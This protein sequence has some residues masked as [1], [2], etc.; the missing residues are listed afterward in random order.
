MIGGDQAGVD[1]LDP[2]F[3][4]LAPGRGD[5]RAHRRPRR[6]GDARAE[7]GY[8]HAGPNG[9]GHFVK[10][11]HNGIEYGM[12]QAIAEGFDILRN[13][14]RRGCPRACARPRPRRHRRGLAAR[15]RRHVVAARS[16]GGGAGRGSRARRV[17]GPRGGLRR[18]PLDGAGR[19]RGGGAGRRADRLALHALPLAPGPHLRREGAVG[20]AQGFGGH[21]EPKKSG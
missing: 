1:R 20:D 12:M 11:I 16:D 21:V 17:L 6:A 2:I 7:Q 4:A 15:Q 3:A 5:I 8:L 14:A 18:R 9:A 13:A 19:H 10:M